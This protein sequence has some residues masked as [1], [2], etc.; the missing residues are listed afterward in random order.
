MECELGDITQ[1]SQC[2]KHQADSRPSGAEVKNERTSS[3]QISWWGSEHER[4]YT[5]TSTSVFIE[6]KIVTTS[7]QSYV[8][9]LSTR[10]GNQNLY[11][12]DLIEHMRLLFCKVGYS[13]R[14]VASEMFQTENTN[15]MHSLLCH[16]SVSLHALTEMST[17]NL[18]E[19]R[20]RPAHKA[21][22][23]TTICEPI[24]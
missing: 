14:D 23:F 24:V 3:P 13:R 5:S 12:G 4:S 16:F 15:K 19:G 18:P 17:S 10:G 7:S 20:R 6:T 22:N 11:T 9:L 8:I 2:L 21:Y 1:R